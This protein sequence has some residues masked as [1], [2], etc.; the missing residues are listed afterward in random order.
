[1]RRAISANITA[2]MGSATNRTGT[3]LR[4]EHKRSHNGPMTVDRWHRVRPL[5]RCSKYAPEKTT[6]PQLM[7]IRTTSNVARNP[8]LNSRMHPWSSRPLGVAGP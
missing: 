5:E 8:P 1:M 7:F 2:S 6:A 4:W 3:G